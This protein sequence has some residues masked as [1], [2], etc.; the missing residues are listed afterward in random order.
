MLRA[1]EVDV[2]AFA[3]DALAPL[4]GAE[5]MARYEATARAAR[6]V[7]AGRTALNLNS[8]ATGG[9]VAEML[10]TLLAH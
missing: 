4:T 9:G 2:Q 10:Q 8:T 1:Q 5:R 3:V 6:E 7:L